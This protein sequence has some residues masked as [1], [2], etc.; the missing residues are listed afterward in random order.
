MDLNTHSFWCPDRRKVFGPGPG[1][2]G[3]ISALPM[4]FPAEDR[5]A[6]GETAYRIEGDILKIFIFEKKNIF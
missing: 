3:D 1:N 4:A 2:Q 6:L 5:D